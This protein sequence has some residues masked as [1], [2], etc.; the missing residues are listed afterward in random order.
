MMAQGTAT[1]IAAVPAWI[2]AMVVTTAPTTSIIMA[3]SEARRSPTVHIRWKARPA[4]QSIGPT[5][6][7]VVVSFFFSPLG[8]RP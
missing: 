3:A 5:P 4:A 2:W 8:R 6:V 1:S 7:C